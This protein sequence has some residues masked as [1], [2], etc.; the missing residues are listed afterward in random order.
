MRRQGAQ[1]V[2]QVARAGRSSILG[3]KAQ[4]TRAEVRRRHSSHLPPGK[5]I[6]RMMLQPGR[7]VRQDHPFIGVTAMSN[8]RRSQDASSAAGGMSGFMN[9]GPVDALRARAA[10]APRAGRDAQVVQTGFLRIRTRESRESE[11][12]MRTPQNWQSAVTMP[13]SAGHVGDVIGRVDRQA[14]AHPLA[15]QEQPKATGCGSKTRGPSSGNR[16][17]SSSVG[18]TGDRLARDPA[19]Y[20]AGVGRLQ[21]SSSSPS[22]ISPGTRSPL[23][24]LPPPEAK[25]EGP[26]T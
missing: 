23:S 8:R 16:R 12:V 10:R 18:C 24:P 6:A 9:R 19:R 26:R 2:D 11:F 5:A 22:R 4:G 25:G 7:G 13:S 20:R 21:F 14:L 15:E 17:T 1:Q 3:L